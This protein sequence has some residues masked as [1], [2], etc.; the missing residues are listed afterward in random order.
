[1]LTLVKTEQTTATG[2]SNEVSAGQ[3]RLS[4]AEQWKNEEKMLQ[5][6]ARREIM[7]IDNMIELSEGKIKFYIKVKEALQII[8]DTE[9]LE[10][11]SEE[12]G[13]TT[14]PLLLYYLDKFFSK[15]IQIEVDEK[16]QFIMIDL[17]Q[18]Q[19]NRGTHLLQYLVQKW[20]DDH[21]TLTR[22]PYG[23]LYYLFLSTE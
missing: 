21:M 15:F 20:L 18:D 8:I 2:E 13:T 23:L 7:Q 11:F 9:V 12:L 5:Q 4:L 14:Y 1:M 16:D 3:K 10:T 6:I 22:M 19:S 17:N